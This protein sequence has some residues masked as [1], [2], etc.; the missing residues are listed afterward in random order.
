M[1]CH[2]GTQLECCKKNSFHG[3]YSQQKNQVVRDIVV[4]V[5]VVG[6]VVCKTNFCVFNVKNRID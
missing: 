6:V 5:V 2:A 4:V 1:E 3:F